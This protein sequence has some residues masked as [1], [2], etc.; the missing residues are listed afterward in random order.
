MNIKKESIVT[1]SSGTITGVI[2]WKLLAFNRIDYNIP[3][4][5]EASSNNISMELSKD[6]MILEKKKA[7]LIRDLEMANRDKEI[8]RGD[9]EK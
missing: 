5:K 4:A 2:N 7:Q 9:R 3:S 6:R 8:Y 1:L